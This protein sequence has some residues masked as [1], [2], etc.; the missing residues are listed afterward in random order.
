MRPVVMAVLAA[1]LTVLALA[2]PSAAGGCINTSKPVEGSSPDVR[3]DKCQFWSGVLRV[4]VGTV[5]KWT[6]DDV[7]PHVISGI[8]W[9][10]T[11][12][13]LTT[14]GTFSHTFTEAGIYPYTCTLHPGMSAVVFVGD[15]AAPAAQQST[16][17]AQLVAAPQSPATK[18]ADG[19]WL[20]AAIL[21]A[22][23]VG[24]TGFTV[25]RYLGR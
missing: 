20:A 6:N 5:V 25:G 21:A 24:V 4:P 18:S 19:T 22:T 11:D 14:G 23:L 8:N 13:M 17:A 15:V 9:G 7:F 12:Q 3:I 16:I 10:R 2:S 1:A